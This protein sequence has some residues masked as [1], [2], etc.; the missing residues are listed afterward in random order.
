MQIIVVMKKISII[1]IALLFLTACKKDKPVVPV[2]EIPVG[3]LELVDSFSIDVPE[4]SGL[5]FGPN[6][7]TLLTVSDHTNQVY[8]LD[9]VGK[10]IRTL[11]YTGK[12][13]EGVTYNHK[14]NIIAIA[15]EADREIT[16]LDYGSGNK[17][18][19]YKIDI[20]FGSDNSGLEG[21][22]FN[23]NNNMYYI[24]NE[25]NPDLMVIWN[26]VYGIISEI[27]LDFAADYSGIFVDELHSLLWIVSDQS[28]SIYKCDYNAKVLM[29]FRLD[30]VKFEG[31]V[32]EGDTIY[33]VNDASAELFVYQIK[34]D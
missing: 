24:L 18:D 7:N 2:I 28:R 20:P 19:T 16:L 31:I 10:V 12:D 21:I 32:V 5:C 26:P 14:E 30:E 17:I 25:T 15:E 6:G 29:E 8:E 23:T 13:L 3:T 1:A 4:P 34:N 22:S 11:E 33:L 9:K 27:N